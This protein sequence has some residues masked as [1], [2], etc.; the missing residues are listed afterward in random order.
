MP[1][2][3]ERAPLCGPDDETLGLRHNIITTTHGFRAA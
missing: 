2:E 1:P 3:D